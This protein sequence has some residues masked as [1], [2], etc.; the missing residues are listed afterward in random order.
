M[1][2][3]GPE[4]ELLISGSHLLVNEYQKNVIVDGGVVISGDTICAV[5]GRTELKERYPD[6]VEFH[7]PNGLIMPGLVNSHSH[8]SMACFRGLADNLP[9]ATTFQEH[10]SSLKAVLDRE[11]VYHSALL[12]IAE[13]IKSGTTSFCDMS[14]LGDEVA[15]AAAETGIRGWIGETL[16]DL[17][18]DCC[19][20]ADGIF[21]SLEEMFQTYRNHP[22]ISI[23]VAPHSISH[24]TSEL[25]KKARQFAEK[26]NLLYVIHLA[27]TRGEI[28]ACLERCGKTPVR[29]LEEQGLLNNQ[30]L[31]ANCVHLQ[32]EDIELLAKRGV[33]VSHCPESNM[34]SGSGTAPLARFLS[35][36]IPVS[37]GTDSFAAN[38]DLDLFGEMNSLAKAHKVASMNP[39]LMDAETT[40][41]L[42]TQGGAS[43]LGGAG[44]I[45]TLEIGKKG[46]LIVLDLKQPHLTPLYNIPSHL[47]YAARGGDV[48]H[49]VINGRIVMRDRRLLTLRE[50]D[51]LAAITEISKRI[52]DSRQ[53]KISDNA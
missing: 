33:K 31:A 15:R 38:N 8:A 28:E 23:V 45:G 30:T 7:E 14:L 53:E 4:K 39:T 25:L 10:I 3:N 42:A 18:A 26:N 19:G 17:P 27:E 36:G 24:C 5:G 16:Y 13:M 20:P 1:L 50:D 11:I 49:S 52:P 46:D 34:K 51:C 32:E 29:Y 9:P 48:I 43:V 35:H 22:L 37:I 2:T 40:L 47:V 12:A 44:R 21:G 41:H 6:S